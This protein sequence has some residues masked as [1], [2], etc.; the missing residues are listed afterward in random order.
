ML[1]Y[2]TRAT[3]KL[4]AGI[5]LYKQIKISKTYINTSQ[6]ALYKRRREQ[7]RSW[8]WKQEVKAEYKCNTNHT[9]YRVAQKK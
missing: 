9:V 2:V 3:Y 7:H 5:I 1:C 6:N 8:M 4:I